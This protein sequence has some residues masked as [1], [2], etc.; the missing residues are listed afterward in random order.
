[1]HNKIVKCY[2][3]MCSNAPIQMNAIRLYNVQHKI[4]NPS[5][6]RRVTVF[7]LCAWATVTKDT[8]LYICNGKSTY[9]SVNNVYS[10]GR[11]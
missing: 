1:M 7:I 3:C 2:T 9:K 8:Q 11:E 10:A 6:G 4:I 5:G